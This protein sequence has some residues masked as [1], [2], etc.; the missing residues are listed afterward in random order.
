MGGPDGLSRQIDELIS[1]IPRRPD[2]TSP[3]DRLTDDELLLL[4]IWWGKQNVEN[5][6]H[7]LP[8]VATVFSRLRRS[9]QPGPPGYGALAGRAVTT[10][11]PVKT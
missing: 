7:F 3:L 1:S 10:E 11:G 2:D 4:S 9:R 6:R 5:K 8:A